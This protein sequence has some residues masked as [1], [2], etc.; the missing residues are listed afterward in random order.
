M[1]QSPLEIPTVT[2][3]IR[4]VLVPSSM[5]LVR[6]PL[7]LVHHFSR[8]LKAPPTFQPRAYHFSPIEGLIR[9]NE[10]GVG[11][12]GLTL[13]E[14]PLKISASCVVNFPL[15][16][17]QPLTPLPSVVGLLV[18]NV[19]GRQLVSLNVLVP[20]IVCVYSSLTP[21]HLSSQHI[22]HFVR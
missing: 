3:P 5:W 17:G 15:T 22:C 4:K 14:I 12:K 16:V 6:L 11:A 18:P 2:A 7:S 13:I 9:K 21:L 19:K 10:D 8:R 20:Y 1:L